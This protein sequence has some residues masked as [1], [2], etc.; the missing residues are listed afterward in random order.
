MPSYR[1]ARSTAA[2]MR[3]PR[4]RSTP[5]LGLA[6]PAVRGGRERIARPDE[7]AELITALT[8]ADRALWAT[9]LY[10]GLRRGELQALRW[11]DLDFERGLIRV[12]RGWDRV[13]GPIEPKSRAGRRRVPLSAS[14]RKHVVAHRLLQ[15]RGSEGLCFGAT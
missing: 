5:T 10:S 13:A 11:E 6:L 3:D 7:A 9:A 2:R 12:V 8:E 14:L 1:C 4:W 15:G